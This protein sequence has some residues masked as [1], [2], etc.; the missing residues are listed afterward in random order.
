MVFEAVEAI[1]EEGYYVVTLSFRP[2][3]DFSGTPGQEQFFV[4]KEGAAAVRQVLSIPR[5]RG[6]FPLL[7]VAIG[8]VVVG[9]IAA[10]G[11]VFALGGSGGDG[12]PVAVVIPTETP[13]PTEA[14]TPTI[15]PTTDTIILTPAPTRRMPTRN[16]TFTPTPAPRP[17]PMPSASSYYSRG[18][19]YLVTGKYQVAI[20]QFTTAIRLNPGYTNA[21]NDRGNAYGHLAN[22]AGPSRTTTRP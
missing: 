3:G 13:V 8:L 11:A 10:V 5:R 16:P 9:V 18:Y 6:G 4:E 20:D 21:Y 17:T 1:E 14:P 19:V 22:A 15:A 2:Q 7:P 12:A